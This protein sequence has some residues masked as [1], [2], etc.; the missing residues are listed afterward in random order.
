MPQFFFKSFFLKDDNIV[1]KKENDKENGIS[2]DKENCL[3]YNTHFYKKKN[4]KVEYIQSK[5]ITLLEQYGKVFF[6]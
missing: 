2:I 5:E 6:R 3:L 4:R 1:F